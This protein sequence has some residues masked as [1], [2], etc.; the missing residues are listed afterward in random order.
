MVR[1]GYHK[2]YY[3]ILVCKQEH[4]HNNLSFKLNHCNSVYC[5][6]VVQIGFNPTLYSADEDAGEVVFIVENGNPNSERDVTV[7]FST[8]DGTAG[9][10]FT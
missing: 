8:L 4:L 9:G 10:T 7:Q 5:I 2:D 6:P 1:C 3:V